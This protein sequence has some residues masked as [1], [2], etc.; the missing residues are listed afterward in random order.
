[1]VIKNMQDVVT[2]FTNKYEKSL[3]ICIKNILI[4]IM[5]EELNDNR[6]SANDTIDVLIEKIERHGYIV[7]IK[8]PEPTF[9]YKT[10]NLDYLA[11][12]NQPNPKVKLYS[13]VKEI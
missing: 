8:I 1:M 7:L 12:M 5:I 3:E 4:K 10:V 11:T 9:D 2:N 6:F 13:F